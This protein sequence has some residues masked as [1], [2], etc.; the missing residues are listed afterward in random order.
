[1]QKTAR[2]HTMPLTAS[3]YRPDMEKILLHEN[4]ISEGIKASRNICDND[5][6]RGG[7]ICNFFHNTALPYDYNTCISFLPHVYECGLFPRS[8]DNE[9]D[10]GQTISMTRPLFVTG[11]FWLILGLGAG[12]YAQAELYAPG[13]G[14]GTNFISQPNLAAY[15]FATNVHRLAL[16]LSFPFIALLG[17]PLTLS[18][19]Q[20]SA[21]NSRKPIII[22]TAICALSFAPFVLSDSL[23]TRHLDTILQTYLVASIILTTLLIALHKSRSWSAIVLLIS[24]II[25]LTF[26][27]VYWRVLNIYSDTS[28]FTDTYYA[29]ALRHSLGIVFILLA[30][31]NLTVWMNSLAAK[32]N[33]FITF[34][35][36]APIVASGVAFARQQAILGLQGMPRGYADYPYAFADAQQ[37]ASTLA[38]IMTAFL[39]LFLLR[40]TV[41][42]HRRDRSTVAD[43]F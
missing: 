20:Y 43:S 25:P 22:I 13:L 27:A 23:I 16:S 1:M 35:L 9:A 11:L 21:P 6:N 38:F 12:L 19:Q 5:Q 34:I 4:G 15:N 36:I 10:E 28:F 39:A 24:V 7:V 33:V 26:Y 14:D 17:L 37:N 40:L 41:A 18:L 31:A 42:Y 30:L 8:V 29:L 2:D 32:L 3:G